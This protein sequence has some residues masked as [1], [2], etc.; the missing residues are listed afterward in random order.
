MGYAREFRADIYDVPEFLLKDSSWTDQSWHNDA[1]PRFE[2]KNLR[3][4]IWVAEMEQG[5]REFD[6]WKQYL[7][8]GLLPDGQLCDSCLF[9]TDDKQALTRWISMYKVKVSLEAAVA[10]ANE[11]EEPNEEL[12]DALQTTLAL[13]NECMDKLK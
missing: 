1:C 6:D 2:N 3:L 5:D 10:V 9:E 8:V 12:Q 11:M 4:A 7:V 13:Y